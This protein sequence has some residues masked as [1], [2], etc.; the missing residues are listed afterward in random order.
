M[1]YP[2]SAV[3]GIRPAG[4]RT[5]ATTRR[6]GPAR[7]LEDLGA[8]LGLAAAVAWMLLG[9]ESTVRGGERHYRD[10]LWNVPFVLT[11]A[12]F[13]IVYQVQRHAFSRLQRL[14]AFA[15]AVSMV[16]V[17]VGNVG[18]I[19]D[20]DA[21]KTLGFP[22]G[23]TVWIAAMVAFGVATVRAGVLPRRTGWAIILLEPLSIVAGVVLSPIAGL[24]D[25]GNFSGAVEKG[26]ALWLIAAA[27]A[28]RAHPFG[29]LRL[30]LR[31]PRTS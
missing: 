1:T 12:T 25:R 3:P 7:V 17:L 15:L 29:R 2:P 5:A 6:P 20:N 23:P 11:I 21:L 22:V 13:A 30:A 31:R 14:A 18:V 8:G 10:V 16:A 24:Y 4:E 27:L 26:I 19:T 28:E 9:L